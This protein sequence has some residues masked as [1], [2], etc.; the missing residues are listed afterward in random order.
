[1]EIDGIIKKFESMGIKLGIDANN[2]LAVDAPFHLL[3]P[4]IFQEIN[5]HRLAIIDYFANQS[6]TIPMTYDQQEIWT[7]E[8]L[9]ADSE[10]IYN[11]TFGF[12]LKGTLNVAN[13]KEAIN[14]LINRHEALRTIPNIDGETQ[15]VLTTLSID[16]PE[17]DLSALSD[18][19]KKIAVE[20]E[21]LAE[22]GAPFDL[23][24]GPLIRFKLI[25]QAEGSA[26]LLVSTHHII[27]DGWSLNVIGDNLAKIYTAVSNG[28]T[29][30]LQPVQ[31]YSHFVKEKI[32]E[33]DSAD[34]QRAKQY[35][36]NEFADKVPQ[37]EI[38]TD[39]PRPPRKSFGAISIAKTL[40]NELVAEIKEAAKKHRTSFYAYML[41]AFETV[42][43]RL[44]GQENIVVGIPVAGQMQNADTDLVG[45]CANFLPIRAD[46][47]ETPSFSSLAKTTHLKIMKGLAHQNFPIG[48]LI[49]LLPIKR[50]SSRLPLI[51]VAFNQY[52]TAPDPQFGDFEIKQL[53][54]PTVNNLYELFIDIEEL[55]Q[56]LVLN[57]IGNSD[58]FDEASLHRLVDSYLVLLKA[59]IQSPETPVNQLP[60][61]SEDT[62]KQIVFDWNQTQMAYDHNGTVASLFNAQAERSGEKTAVYF[63][64]E[65]ISYAELNQR[66]NQLAN[67]LVAQGIQPDQFVGLCVERSIELVVALLAI[68]KAGAAYLPMDPTYPVDRLS[69]MLEDT[70]APILITQSHLLNKLPSITGTTILLDSDREQI[71]SQNKEAPST[72]LQSH[73][74][75]YVI[76]TSGST[77][78]PKGVLITHR[79]VVNFLHT[80]RKRPGITSA[81]S[82]LAVTTL[83]FDIAVLEVFLPLVTGATLVLASNEMTTNPQEL[84]S[85]FERHNITIMQ[86]TPATW[87]LLLN[88]KWQVPPHLKIL[89]GGEALPKKLAKKLS[90]TGA[91]LWN[92]Y[93]PTE[94]TIWSSVWQVQQGQPVLIGKPI[95]NTQMYILDE[96]QQPV[97]IGATGELW[98]AGDG[99]ANGYLNRPDLTN[100]R[101][102]P[103]PFI[104]GTRMYHTGDLARFLPDG[105][106][107][108]LGR[109]DFQVKIRGFR[110]ELGEIEAI[111]ESHQGIR[112][113]VVHP[114][115]FGEE[116]KR[117]VGYYLANNGFGEIESDQLRQFLKNSLPHYMIPSIFVHLESF[118]LTPNGKVNRLAL[119]NPSGRLESSKYV[120]PSTQIETKLVNIWKE[121]VKVEHIGIEDDF[122]EL[123]GH[124][125][126]VTRLLSTIRSLFEVEVSFGNFFD[127]PTIKKLGEHIET[128]LWSKNESISEFSAE[129]EELEI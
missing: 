75:A 88:S 28:E 51:S 55:S 12:E 33:E 118:P 114:V 11:L 58:L 37:L 34:F 83:S 95:G 32:A 30:H 86:A 92:M 40:E 48:R 54:L 67:H 94:T 59:A 53:I 121:L 61:M 25:H 17:T 1:M 99:V 111:L 7:A 98:I 103:N 29:A 72:A 27:S 96:M 124:S 38:P 18:A 102:V 125:L 100:E 14:Q 8:Q 23:Q 71:A 84:I 78:K 90:A 120:A 6:K 129:Y 81:D 112:E 5:G 15:E 64:D 13:L 10:S 89:S 31:D 52:P 21:I 113:A 2:E 69:Y 20:K 42:L 60:I 107:E 93:G 19:E 41:T 77:G 62:R 4:D 79:N 9:S 65:S 123:G 104:N 49:N 43:H 76:H 82:L 46:F 119:P 35:W 56:G 36:L 57:C 74:L 3:T 116:D 39:Y 115:D 97:A 66:A 45:F 24:K 87:Q 50:D 85:E 105:N 122:F 73:H 128:S 109:V 110:I 126:L 127:H 63:K 26:I 91:E 68:H 80:M 70:Q 117:L 16:L 106:I 22:I 47:E 44:S 108:C 101:F